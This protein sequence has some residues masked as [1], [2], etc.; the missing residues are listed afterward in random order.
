MTTH[1]YLEP[2]FAA[3]RSIPSLAWVPL[4]PLLWR[5]RLS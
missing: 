1:S 2:T 3:L 5:Q 4:L